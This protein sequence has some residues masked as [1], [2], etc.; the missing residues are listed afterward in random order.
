MQ[1][2]PLYQEGSAASAYR[3]LLT[4]SAYAILPPF[5]HLHPRLMKTPGKSEEEMHAVIARRPPHLSCTENL[6]V[7][8]FYPAASG[9]E[10]AAQHLMHKWGVA[11]AATAFLC[12]DDN[13]LALAA[14]VGKAFL[15]SISAVSRLAMLGRR[16]GAGLGV[17]L[18]GVQQGSSAWRLQHTAPDAQAGYGACCHCL[19]V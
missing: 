14:V 18:D 5:P 17:K 11:P 3:R 6:G 1:I 15:P 4:P 7:M 9:K 10:G 8:D 13:D 12:D 19:S 16:S 2:L